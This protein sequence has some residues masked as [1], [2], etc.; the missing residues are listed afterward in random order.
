MVELNWPVLDYIDFNLLNESRFSSRTSIICFIQ[1]D[2]FGGGNWPIDE[3]V[4]IFT[5]FTC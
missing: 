1:P 2:K 5:D 4:L 3:E